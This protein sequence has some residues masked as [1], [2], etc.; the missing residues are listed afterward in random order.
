MSHSTTADARQNE[1][2]VSIAVL[3]TRTC[4]FVLFMPLLVCEKTIAA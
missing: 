2:N 1:M 4:F 3:S